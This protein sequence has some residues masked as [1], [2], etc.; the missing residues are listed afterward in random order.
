MLSVI[1]P[2]PPLSSA[3]AVAAVALTVVAPAPPLTVWEAD[4]RTM[5]SP[6]ALWSLMTRPASALAVKM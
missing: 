6:P 5:V 4:P 1:P 3:P 2:E